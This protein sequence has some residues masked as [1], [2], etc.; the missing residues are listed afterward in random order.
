MKIDEK[1]LEKL[2]LQKAMPVRRLARQA[3]VN[4]STIYALLKGKTKVRS[5]FDVIGKL[6]FVLE[7]DATEIIS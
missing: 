4:V 5:R 1:K 2:L 7:V 3:G 6:A